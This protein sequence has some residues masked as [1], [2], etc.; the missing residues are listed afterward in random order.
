MAKTPTSPSPRRRMS[1]D[2]RRGVIVETALRL[3]AENGFRGA[4]TRQLAQAAGVTEPVLYLHFKT[5]RD[6]YSAIIEHLAQAVEVR[7]PPELLA[8]LAGAGDE[9]FF[10]RLAG[11]ML[12]WYTGDPSRIRVL[13][14]SSLEGHE[15]SDLFF[16]RHI[17]PFYQALAAHIERRIK[18]GAFRKEDSMIAARAFC[19]MVGQYGESISVF[20]RQESRRAMKHTLATI[21]RIFLYGMRKRGAAR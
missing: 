21:V 16:E 9:E 13:L 8:G 18:E 1:S 2:Q 14:F 11:M 6:L 7:E 15:L 4:T 3:F 10:G 20:G 17:A 12:D 19:G 5:K